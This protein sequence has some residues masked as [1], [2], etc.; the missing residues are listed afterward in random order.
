MMSGYYGGS[1]MMGGAGNNQPIMG[2]AGY[3]WMFGGVSAP[4]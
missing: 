3:Q 4:G 1:P 2:I